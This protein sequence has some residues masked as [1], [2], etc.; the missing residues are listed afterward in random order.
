MIAVVDYGV[1][2]FENI[3]GALETLKCD[4]ILTNKEYDILKSDKVILSGEGDISFTI[5]QLHKSNLFT[6]LRVCRKPILG[7]NTGMQIFADNFK[8]F[9]LSGIGVFSGSIEKFNSEI[10]KIPFKGLREVYIKTGSKLFNGIESGEKFY[11]DHSYYLPVNIYTTSSAENNTPFSA[12]VETGNYFGVQFHPE[13]SGEAGM[14][15]LK[16]FIQI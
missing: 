8:D 16:N 12:S 10:S 1:P 13:K 5:K 6:M 3:A 2:G 14:L 15:L 9:K 4:Y 7:I 11:F